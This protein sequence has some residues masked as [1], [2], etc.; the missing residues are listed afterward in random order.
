MIFILLYD[1][2]MTPIEYPEGHPIYRSEGMSAYWEFTN[3]TVNF[4]SELRFTIIYILLFFLA[5]SNKDKH[6]KL[7]KF[8]FLFPVWYI[9]KIIP[10]S[11]SK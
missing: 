3:A 7:A 11:L 8:L 5:M 2:V 10:S 6:P 1:L 4:Y 9:C